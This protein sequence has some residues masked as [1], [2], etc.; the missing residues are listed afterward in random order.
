MRKGNWLQYIKKRHF[1]IV[2]IL[3]IVF[4]IWVFVAKLEL[5]FRQPFHTKTYR[6]HEAAAFISPNFIFPYPCF[7]INRRAGYRIILNDDCV[8]F[9]RRYK[10]LLLLSVKY[11]CKCN[12][13]YYQNNWNLKL[14]Y[15]LFIFCSHAWLFLPR[16]YRNWVKTAKGTCFFWVCAIFA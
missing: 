8:C 15:Y 3:F 9:L 14:Y 5:I 2:I 16:I 12:N 1:G 6:F 11:R 13:G 4:I 10:N 7:F